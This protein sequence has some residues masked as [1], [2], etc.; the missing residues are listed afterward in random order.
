MFVLSIYNF[1]TEKESLSNVLTTILQQ[2]IFTTFTD[3]VGNKNDTSF[4]LSLSSS[5]QKS[6]FWELNKVRFL[7]I[8]HLCIFFTA[9]GFYTG[10][11]CCPSISF[12]SQ[13][14]DKRYVFFFQ[15][16]CIRK[17]ILC[18]GYKTWEEISLAFL[19]VNCHVCVKRARL[20]LL[21]PSF[22]SWGYL[23][24]KVIK[25]LPKDA[26]AIS[27]CHLE[28]ALKCT[29]KHSVSF[30]NRQVDNCNEWNRINNPSHWI[31]LGLTVTHAPSAQSC[32]FFF[33][34]KIRQS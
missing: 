9:W 18:A 5:V 32:C 34:T 15:L 31:I 27:C 2:T 22:L 11:L 23:E 3:T 20:I 7:M 21:K 24:L 4:L 8:T 26:F 30:L 17:R 6:Y 29:E 1:E 25:I 13:A 10:P 12:T 28:L 19:K 33:W 16:W 14:Y